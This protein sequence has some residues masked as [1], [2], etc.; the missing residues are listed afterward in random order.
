M[1]QNSQHLIWLKSQHLKIFRFTKRLISPALVLL[2]NKIEIYS[3]SARNRYSIW[4]R[5]IHLLYQISNWN[6]SPFTVIV[7]ALQPKSGDSERRLRLLGVIATDSEAQLDISQSHASRATLQLHNRGEKR[8]WTLHPRQ[9]NV[10]AATGGVGGHLQ[11]PNL[12]CV[13]WKVNAKKYVSL[14]L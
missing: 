3:A 12:V 7:G 13:D 14:I 5:V 1:S 8:L 10:Q 2:G 4:Q 9:P 6:S 11:R